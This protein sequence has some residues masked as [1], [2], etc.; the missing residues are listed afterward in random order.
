MAATA[1]ELPQVFPKTVEVEEDQGFLVSYPPV[2]NKLW[3][4]CEVDVGGSTKVANYSVGFNNLK[5]DFGSITPFSPAQ[6]C[7]VRVHGVKRKSTAEWIFKADSG[8]G[9]RRAKMQVKVLPKKSDHKCVASATT[10]CERW[11]LA[12]KQKMSCN[13]PT[14]P[15]WEKTECR[16]TRRGAMRTM[17]V[18]ESAASKEE[19]STG[20]YS[21]VQEVDGM[22]VLECS[23]P[24]GDQ[25]IMCLIRNEGTGE[26]FNIQP[27]L[28]DTRYSARMTD[29]TE[30][31]CQFEIPKELTDNEEGLW[32]MEMTRKDA[33]KEPH[34]C[35]YYLGMTKF[36]NSMRTMAGTEIPIDTLEENVTFECVNDAPYPIRRCYLQSQFEPLFQ[37]GVDKEEMEKGN[38]KFKVN[39]KKQIDDKKKNNWAF[40]CGFNGPKEDDLDIIQPFRV[41]YFEN[42]VID[43][44]VNSAEKT[45]ECHYIY[46]TA[47]KSCVFVSP[48]ESI[49]SVPSDNYKAT[50]F[51]YHG[52]GFSKGACGVKFKGDQLEAGQWTCFIDVEGERG[53][54]KEALQTK[55][56]LEV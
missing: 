23:I 45:L 3:K 34:R 24:K 33:S 17:V 30:N 50:D 4:H 56:G 29:F 48:S 13:D 15:G 54:A 26:V 9:H 14:P 32:T 22:K 36:I 53:N 40:H 1:V 31:R 2:D 27:G 47:I 43:G 25:V 6:D 10:H 12:D 5:T 42:K 38:C 52:A 55:E 16:I 37:F 49:I 35:R 51:D 41:R 11:N 46:R 20:G 39:L 18:D 19:N 7:G 28:L 8:E 21:S 44:K